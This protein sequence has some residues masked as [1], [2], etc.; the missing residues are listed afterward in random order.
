MIDMD[1]AIKPKQGLTTPVSLA[2]LSS[3]MNF[4]RI[5]GVILV[6]FQQVQSQQHSELLNGIAANQIDIIKGAKK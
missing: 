4:I 1:Y 6:Y 3:L 5:N 2:K